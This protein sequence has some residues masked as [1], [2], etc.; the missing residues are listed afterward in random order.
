[1]RMSQRI[2]RS[3]HS[4]ADGKASNY[5]GASSKGQ[6]PSGQPKSLNNFEDG[7]QDQD[8]P[9]VALEPEDKMGS[10]FLG[11]KRGS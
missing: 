10:A 4:Q 7:Q 5:E 9:V 8:N 1:M 11:S 2:S 6:S 3:Q